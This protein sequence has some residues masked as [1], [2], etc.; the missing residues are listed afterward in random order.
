MK[1]GWKVLIGLMVVFAVLVGVG[2]ALSPPEGASPPGGEPGDGG[3]EPPVEPPPEPI[4]AARLTNYS[5]R[6]AFEWDGK[7]PVR[8]FFWVVNVTLWNDGNTDL[9]P[10]RLDWRLADL[11]GDFLAFP[12]ERF[13]VGATAAPGTSSEFQLIF[14][15]PSYAS[16]VKVS[17]TLPS[18]EIVST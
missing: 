7:N 18:G 6:V 16:P 12:D 2:A 13:Y 3:D 8:T 10:A 17:V 1:T 9:S 11:N 4:Y 5:A 14:D 15:L